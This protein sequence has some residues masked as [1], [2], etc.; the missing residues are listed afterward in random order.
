MIRS[1][2]ADRVHLSDEESSGILKTEV[3]C[4]QKKKK[5]KKESVVISGTQLQGILDERWRHVRYMQCHAM[6]DTARHDVLI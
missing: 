2:L 3:T 4:L 1:C 6:Y 5:K